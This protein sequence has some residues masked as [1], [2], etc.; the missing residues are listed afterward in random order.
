MLAQTRR[1]DEIVVVDDGSTDDPGAV[2]HTFP[3]VR[4]VRQEIRGLSSARNTG[5]W[6]SAS[7]YI[8]FLDADDRLLPIALEA[9]LACAKTNWDRGFVYGG[10]RY[11]SE[12]GLPLGYEQYNPIGDDAY[13]TFLRGNV[14][15]MH[16]T[17]LYRR[18]RLVEV[19]G[20][21]QRV[22]RCEDYDMYIRLA[23]QYPVA[24]DSSRSWTVP[25]ARSEYF[26]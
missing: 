14:I 2:V 3:E 6:A 23:H 17:V 8:T 24:S 7:Q 12:A 9:G 4:I 18:D 21:D 26:P 15:G 22:R 19:N 13:Q 25:L 20:F 5:L 1:A 16:A 11:I 10:H